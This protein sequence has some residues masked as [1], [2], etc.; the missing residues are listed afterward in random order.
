MNTPSGSSTTVATPAEIT[1]PGLPTRLAQAE[2]EGLATRPLR[3]A[4]VV[5]YFPIASE[6]FILNM[7]AQLVAL[8]H[9]VDIYALWRLL[10]MPEVGDHPADTGAPGVALAADAAIRQQLMASARSPRFP[11][12]LGARLLSSL[13][14]L[15]KGMSGRRWLALRALNP[16]RFGRWA[17]N[18]RLLHEAAM[19][20]VG[21]HYDVV[22]CQFA[23]LAPHVE[24]L[25]SLGVFSAP[26]CV[27][28]RGIDITRRPLELGVALY[29]RIFARADLVLANCA[30][31]QQRALQLGCPPDKLGVLRT[32][33]DIDAFAWRAPRDPQQ[34]P[35]RLVLVARLVEKKGVRWAILALAHLLRRG[36]QLE[37]TLVGEGPLRAALQQQVR[38]LGIAEHVH[39]RGELSNTQVIGELRNADVLLAPSVRASDGDE[40][41]PVNT[42]KEAMAIGLPVIGTRHGGIPEL[43]EHG[44]NGYLVPERDDAALADAIDRLIA[45]RHRWAEMGLAGR[46]R[47]AFDYHLPTQAQRLASMDR[48]LLALGAAGRISG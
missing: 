15:I 45:E 29:R 8:G 25:R 43:I 28:L 44:V 20:P 10:P 36:R 27:H 35:V 21:V 6:V 48:R 9:Q 47:V 32:G 5:H 18:Q 42:L 22:H 23:D 7:A 40:D 16:L 39:W 1:W 17:L 46:A 30:H 14:L 31:F 2:P 34:L 38:D 4:F 11:A 33:I 19:F 12:A 37:L 26:I 24:R 41:A 3:L 13:H